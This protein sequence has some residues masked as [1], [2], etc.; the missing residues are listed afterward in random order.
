MKRI[1]DQ[2]SKPVVAACEGVTAGIVINLFTDKKLARIRG[3]K[4]VNDESDEATLLPLRR[5]IGDA[6]ALIIKSYAALSQARLPECPLG[7]KVFDTAGTLL[8]I[9]RDLLFDPQ[10][11]AVLSLVVDQAELPAG[12]VLSFC[13]DTVVLRAPIHSKTQFKKPTEKGA[14]PAPEPSPLPTPEK[15]EDAADFPFRN[16]A[17]LLGRRVKK[18]I[19]NGDV[20]VANA[21]DPVTP[22]VILRARENGKLVELTVNSRK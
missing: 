21:E 14:R 18:A 15:K 7:A 10:S 20:V 19:L 1:T 13:K 22:E 12:N 9:L 16:Y 8:G 11:G 6:D 4:V 2:L 3:Y 5:V 17:F